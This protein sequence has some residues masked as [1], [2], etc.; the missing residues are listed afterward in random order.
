[1][2]ADFLD[3]LG[4]LGDALG[5]ISFFS[6][7]VPEKPPPDGAAIRIKAGNPG[8]DNPGMVSTAT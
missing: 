4:L 5:V 3:G 8:G 2:K 6:E 7:L 1:M